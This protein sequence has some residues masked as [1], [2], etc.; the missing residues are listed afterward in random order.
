MWWNKLKPADESSG[1]QTGERRLL[2]VHLPYFV[3]HCHPL[4]EHRTKRWHKTVERRQTSNI[5]SSQGGKLCANYTH[6]LTKNSEFKATS[7]NVMF[8]PTKT[9]RYSV[10][11]DKKQRKAA[12]L[13]TGE[14]KNRGRFH[15]STI[16]CEKR[17]SNEVINRF[18]S[19]K[20]YT[21]HSL[22]SFRFSILLFF[23][24]LFSYMLKISLIK[25]N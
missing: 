8:C 23:S 11:N 18:C 19:N 15:F 25:G 22:Q 13:P 24:L 4:D 2:K 1:P 5:I 3:L 16:L 7:S 12:N 10:N 6:N 21:L 20:K 9:W 14:M 17:R